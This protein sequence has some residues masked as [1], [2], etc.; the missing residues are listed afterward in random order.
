MSSSALSLVFWS[1]RCSVGS[2]LAPERSK[3]VAS[4]APLLIQFNRHF[5]LPPPCVA[6][7]FLIR[8]G[9]HK[10][11]ALFVRCLSGYSLYLSLCISCFICSFLGSS[12][13]T[14]PFRLF[15]R[16]LARDLMFSGSKR[17]VHS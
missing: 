6:G 8:R 10:P 1:S 7:N 4:S 3:I 2:D 14:Q 12:S 15:S 11:I 9:A 13:S 16:R 17:W 5:S